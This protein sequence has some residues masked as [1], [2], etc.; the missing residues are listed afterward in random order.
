MRA[1][2]HSALRLALITATGACASSG[3]SA[4]A[5]ATFTEIYAG[6]FPV[7]TKSQCNFCHSLP[8]NN[9]SNGNLSMGSERSSA[10]A[11]L[12]GKL[13]ASTGCNGN[14]LIV[15]NQ[16]E[17]SLFF[18]KFLENPGCGGQMPLGG[19]VLTDAQREMVRSWIAAGAKDD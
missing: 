18:R 2:A 11:A 4:P 19:D 3:S 8:P 16:A 5:P 9:K 13:S 15:P 6:L 7:N 12:K 17:N 1:L 14:P 10:Y